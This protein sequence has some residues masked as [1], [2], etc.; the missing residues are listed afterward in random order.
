MGW[1]PRYWSA[2]QDGPPTRHII[3]PLADAPVLAQGRTE[4][5][6]RSDR[7]PDGIG[8][9]PSG[10][11]S[12]SGRVSPGTWAST[13]GRW[14]FRYQ[15]DPRILRARLWPGQIVEHLGGYSGWRDGEFERLQVGVVD[16]W[17]EDGYGGGEIVC[18]DLTGAL[19][20]RYATDPA[21]LRLFHDLDPASVYV[22]TLAEAYN[23][24]GADYSSLEVYSTGGFQRAT[25][26]WGAIW[27]DPASELS[28]A[29]P[30]NG[31]G[32]GPTR[33]T[34][35]GYSGSAS[36]TFAGTQQVGKPNHTRFQALA[37]VRGLPPYLLAQIL[38]ST[39]AGSNG[40]WD[41]LPAAWGFGLPGS[42]V[43]PHDMALWAARLS[44]S[45]ASFG[46]YADFARAWNLIA[47]TPVDDGFAWLAERLAGGACWVTQRQGRLVTRGALDPNNASAYATS[48]GL[49]ALE[50]ITERDLAVGRPIRWSAWGGGLAAEYA[51]LRLEYTA[52]I[53]PVTLDYERDGRGPRGVPVEPLATVSTARLGVDS[54]VWL[55]HLRDRLKP[56]LTARAELVELPIANPLAEG[57]CAGDP[58]HLDLRDIGGRWEIGARRGYD[59]AGMVVGVQPHFVRGG[60]IRVAVAMPAPRL[61]AWV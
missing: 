26:G 15:G 12:S 60:P 36:A 28:F 52:A 43:D 41:V 8:L 4:W 48:T 25:G 49:P 38:T 47:E 30:W 53:P 16:S 31:T 3:R 19:S 20:T 42:L 61:D 7:D 14:S 51:R 54:G 32:T 55:Y 2:R 58:L 17:E 33:F 10:W 56:W 46:D 11:M 39:G 40:P 1:S 6:L 22:S 35:T 21:E 23:S 50:R 5:E 57:L 37:L 18:R 59:R 9:V 13:I 44:P 45:A 29:H 34:L 27:V 24:S